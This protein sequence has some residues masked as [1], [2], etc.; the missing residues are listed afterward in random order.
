MTETCEPTTA[1]MEHI[2][3]VLRRLREHFPEWPCVEGGEHQLV[4]FAFYEGCGGTEHCGAILAEAAPFA[5]G[6]E[7]VANHGFSWVMIARDDRR[8]GVAH[9]A[10][11]SPIDLTA[12]EHGT[13]NDEE[14]DQPP[15][16]GRKTSDSLETIVKRVCP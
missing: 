4:A 5:L 15:C 12:L 2:R 13:W 14:Y 8:Y 1:E 3:S 6:Q 16:P 11:S 9:S 10:L 7:L